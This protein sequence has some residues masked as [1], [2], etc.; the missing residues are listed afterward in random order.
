M[1]AIDSKRGLENNYHHQLGENFSGG[2]SFFAQC[3]RLAISTMAVAARKNWNYLDVLSAKYP[4]KMPE[5]VK[6]TTNVGPARI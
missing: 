6:T 1:T 5:R 3:A 2:N 4:I